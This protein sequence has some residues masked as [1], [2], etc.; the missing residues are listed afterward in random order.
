MKTMNWLLRREFWEHKG[1]MFWAPIV[2][3]A[4]MI[5]FVTATVLYG[6]TAGTFDDKVIH[7]TENGQTTSMRTDMSEAFGGLSTA[8][9]Q[10]VADMVANGYL[11][12]GAP[13]LLILAAV[14]F[15]YCLAALNDERRDRS[16]L[17][18]KSLPVSDTETVLSKVLTAAIVA[19]LIT[20]AVATFVSLLLLLIVGTAFAFKG[21]NLFALVLSNRALYLA[22]LQLLGMLPVYAL[23]A[24]PTIGWLL[25]VSAWAKSKVFLWAVGVPVITLIIIKWVDYLLGIGI[26]LQW[27]LHNVLA[28]C[29]LGLI[30]GAYLGLAK[31]DKDLLVNEQHTAVFGAIFQHSWLTLSEPAVWIGA[32][33]GA[34]MIYAAIRL[35][36]W[37][38]EG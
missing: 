17:F 19:P 35:R 26:D 9:K 31:V 4:A 22:P 2:V 6:T 32:I 18:W 10:A 13:L 29:L 11:A 24:L 27:F 3:G 16:I 25:M 15:F 20:I 34:A 38:D 37:Q 28:R 33:A 21:V 36:R 12:A 5:L 30:P 1:A 23:W 8:K 14:V 7:I